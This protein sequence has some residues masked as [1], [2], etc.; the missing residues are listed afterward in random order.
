MEEPL[1]VEGGMDRGAQGTK[2]HTAGVGRAQGSP[3][4]GL[5]TDR[6]LIY[7]TEESRVAT[8]KWSCHQP[9]HGRS[10]QQQGKQAGVTAAGQ[11]NQ[12]GTQSPPR[13]ALYPNN[14][15]ET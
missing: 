5:E 10:R 7:L 3:G 2:T 9:P 11:R 4:P 8:A 6:T 15:D 12:R 13:Q 1:S 14:A